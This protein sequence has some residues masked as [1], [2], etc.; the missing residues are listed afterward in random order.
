MQEKPE[1]IYTYFWVVVLDDD[2][3]TIVQYDLEDGHEI[4]W[5][6]VPIN[7]VSQIAWYPFSEELASKASKATGNICLATQNPVLSMNIPPG[8]IPIVA[9]QNDRTQF[10]Y[11]VCK[12][13]GTEVYWDGTGQLECPKCLSRNVW[14]C[15]ACKEIIDDP[16]LFP[17][18][19]VRCPQCEKSGSPNGLNRLRSLELVVGCIHEVYYK[20]GIDG[21]EVHIW[22]DRGDQIS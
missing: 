18:G 12:N 1:P 7:N 6:N 14:Y 19:E 11:Y 15:K 10:D 17:N 8:S 13:C 21:G 16:L 9:R 4:M 5:S 22:N 20:L 2:V 3:T